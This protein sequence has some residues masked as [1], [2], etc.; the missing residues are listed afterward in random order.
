MAK[1]KH[2]TPWTDVQMNPIAVQ[3]RLNLYVEMVQEKNN[4][5]FK[6]MNFTFSDPPVVMSTYGKKYARIVKV[7]QSNGSR[8]VHTFVNMFNGDI[9]KSGGWNAPAPNGVRGNIFANDFGADRVN[10]N[11]ATYLHGPKW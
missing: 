6:A 3:E 1:K 7:D 9:L 2:T 5:Y 10:D 11:G 8:S 4:A